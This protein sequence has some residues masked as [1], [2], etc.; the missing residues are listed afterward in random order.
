MAKVLKLE[1]AGVEDDFFAV[2]GDSIS[3][4][5]LCG[6]LRRAGHTLRPS[7]VFARRSARGMA[8]C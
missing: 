3:A 2:G 1:R 8:P 7:A 6:E 5:M 4:M